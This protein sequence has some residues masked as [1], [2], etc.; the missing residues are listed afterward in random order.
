[1]VTQKDKRSDEI[2]V[3][4]SSGMQVIVSVGDTVKVPLL[5]A[6]A[7]DDITL[8]DL[9]TGKSV[10]ASV[11]AHGRHPKVS[12]RLF[13]NKVRASRYPRGHRQDFTSISVSAIK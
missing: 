12:G 9:L 13:K 5:A 4:E 11:V 10:T 1:M 6:K 2:A 8:S 7:G 3:I